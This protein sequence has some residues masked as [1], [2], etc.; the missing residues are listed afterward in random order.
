MPGVFP[1][2]LAS[3]ASGLPVNQ[4]QYGFE[5]KWDGVRAICRWD[6]RNLSFYSRN[7]L[8]I[9]RR[10]PELWPI[11]KVFGSRP[12]ILDA[13]VIALDDQQRPS[14]SQLQQRM[15]VNDEQS[16]RRLVNQVPVWLMVFDVLYLDGKSLMTLPWLQRRDYL[17]QL[18]LESDGSPWRVPPAHVGE[19][20]AMLE[21]ARRMRLEG[22]V[23]KHVESIYRPGAR[24][25]DWLKIKIIGDEEFVVGGWVP[26]AGT[27]TN[28][29]GSLLIGQFDEQ[30]RLRFAGGI[31]TG[32]RVPDHRQLTRLLAGLRTPNSPFADP[33]P[34][35]GALFVEPTTVVQV[36]YRRRTPEGM[37]HQGAY[38]GLRND[39]EPREVRLAG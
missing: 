37:V 15:H 17:D 32:F 2:M 6:G 39:K 9:T 8:D 21:A 1:P 24:S 35:R 25:A 4:S 38:K 18:H 36:E 11:A 19:G 28:R 13:E 14:F 34:K 23:A 20:D 29:I 33:I 7:Q 31:G 27:R 16:I 22:L 5:Y 3:L 30:G 10:Y 12:V 26:E